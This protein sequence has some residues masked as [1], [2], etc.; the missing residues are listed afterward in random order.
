MLII[1]IDELIVPLRH[2]SYDELLDYIRESM[3]EANTANTWS[4]FSIRNAF[5]FDNLTSTNHPL[6]EQLAT[7]AEVHML[8]HP[9][10]ATKISERGEYGKSFMYIPNLLTVFN[11]FPLHKLD[12]D[13][14]RRVQKTLYVSPELAIKHHYKQTCPIE[15]RDECPSL[16]RETMTD[17]S[18]LKYG[19]ELLRRVRRVSD[20]IRLT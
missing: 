19:A 10:R 6:V 8:R 7:D 9:V 4:A 16:Y 17:E 18:L 15:S 11:H 1:D 12:T 14:H 20:E 3:P 5:F 2:R 13:E